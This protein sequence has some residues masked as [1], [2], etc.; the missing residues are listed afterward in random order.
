MSNGAAISAPLTV[1]VN[2]TQPGLYA[3]PNFN[4]GGK[5]YLGALFPDGVTYVLPPGTISGITSRQAKPGETIIVYGVGFG[6]VTPAIPAGQ[7]VQQPNSLT[8]PLQV[9]FGQTPATLSYSGLAPG[10]VGLYQ[11]NV[12]VPNVV[13]NDAVPISFPLGGASGAQ[14][15]YTA[16]HN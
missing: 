3:P 7:T 6:P 11:F 10:A 14:T 9:F 15:L 1:N 2:A 16:V 13:N 8:S 4:V 12:V 5:Q